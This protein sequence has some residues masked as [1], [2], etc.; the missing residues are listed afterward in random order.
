M[1]PNTTRRISC[2]ARKYP[3]I[4]PS[5]EFK[6]DIKEFDDNIPVGEQLLVLIVDLVVDLT[7][8]AIDIKSASNLWLLNTPVYLT[9]ATFFDIRKGLRPTASALYRSEAHRQGL[10]RSQEKG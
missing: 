2:N 6:I 5:C 9:R 1:A 10:D 3:V 7:H 8:P 4:Y